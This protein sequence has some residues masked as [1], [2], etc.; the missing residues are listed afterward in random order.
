MSPTT[1]SSTSMTTTTPSAVDLTLVF[2]GAVL[3]LAVLG[4]AGHAGFGRDKGHDQHRHNGAGR[5]VDV[6]VA[7]AHM[8][9]ISAAMAS[10]MRIMG[11]LKVS[12][13]S[14]QKVVGS[15][16]GITLL[17]YFFRDSSTWDW[18]ESVKVHGHSPRYD[19]KEEAW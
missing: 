12:L 5:F 2:L 17:P 3:Q 19:G 10:R 18:S 13:N 16:S 14:A 15:E 7:K 1:T 8:T 9:I 11:S 4:I 6:R